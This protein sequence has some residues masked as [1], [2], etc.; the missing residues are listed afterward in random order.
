MVLP[1]ST[2]NIDFK[3]EGVI[4]ACI[5]CSDIEKSDK[6]TL[7]ADEALAEGRNIFVFTIMLYPPSLTLR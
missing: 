5:N 4:L 1:A 3:R 2:G 6:S 7:S